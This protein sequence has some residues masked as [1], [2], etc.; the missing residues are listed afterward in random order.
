MLACAGASHAAE[1][2]TP[3]EAQA[4]LAKAI[5]H[6]HKVG[7]EQ[8][9]ADFSQRKPPFFERDLYVACFGANHTVTANG[10]FPNLV[11]STA[12]LLK[13]ASGKPLGKAIYDIG[14]NQGEGR[15][16]YRWIN[17]L[18]GRNEGKIGF[19]KRA[20]EDVCLVGAY[21]AP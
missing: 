6:Y 18:T 10:G 3:A 4:M 5:E 2:G 20:G 7:R 14:K 11:G 19:I 21:Q 8:A 1:R 17:P 9:L 16:S 15:L 12:D 13:D